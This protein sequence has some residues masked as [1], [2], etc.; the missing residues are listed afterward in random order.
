MEGSTLPAPFWQDMT[1]VDFGSSDTTDWIA[2]LPVA[3]IEQHGPHLPV[4]TDTA[5]AEGQVRR[6]VE[7][8]PEDLPVTF[9]PVQAVGKSNEHISSP[10]TLTLT[11]ET[12]IR[13]WMEIGESVI[14]AGLRKLVIVN[15][16]G[17]NVPLVDILVRELRVKYNMLAVGTAWARF[18]QPDGVFSER[19]LTFGIHG[20]DVETSIMLHLQGDLVR[21]DL[22]EDFVS[23]QEQL[24]GEFTHLRAHGPHAFGWK[25]QDL[26][27]AGAVGNAAL[28][29]AEKGRLSLDHAAN[30]FIELLKDVHA[31]DP[32]RLWRE[33]RP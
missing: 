7:L 12:A 23:T 32:A 17:G 10:G 20:G 24:T 6:V 28:A 19:E 26:N 16:H 21:M 27:P 29:T 9:L 22:A 15:S 4:F 25:A 1:T 8:L 30:G 13:A 18:G 31:F 3:A 2:V 11:W 5:I 14:R 33:G